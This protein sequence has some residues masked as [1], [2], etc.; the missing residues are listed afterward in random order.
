MNF[1]NEIFSEINALDP[2]V[3]DLR[4]LGL[5]FLIVL[6]L[7]GGF[8]AWKGA[9]PGFYLAVSGVLFGLWGMV[10]P[11]GLKS[12][13]HIWMGFAV[14]I[15]YFVSRILLTLLYY[16][17]VTPIGLTARIFGKDFMD[18]RSADRKSYWIK[19]AQEEYDP[20]RTEKM[21]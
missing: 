21:Y 16:L 14:I 6:T 19:R 2:T 12:V 10:W 15:G 1:I 18:I 4:R 11:G 5:T 17:M 20:V 7:V 8:L 13:Y 3:R 9:L